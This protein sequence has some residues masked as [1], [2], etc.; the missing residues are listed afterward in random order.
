MTWTTFPAIEFW[1]FLAVCEYPLTK[2]RFSLLTNAHVMGSTVS[3]LYVFEG[4]TGQVCFH[5]HYDEMF[6]FRQCLEEQLNI[7]IWRVR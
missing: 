2:A 1:V 5:S 6:Y 4:D 7:E 3:T